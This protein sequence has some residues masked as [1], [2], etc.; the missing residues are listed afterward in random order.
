[1][2]KEL[3]RHLTEETIWMAFRDMTNCLT[4]LVI[5]VIKIIPQQDA[6][7]CNYG[8]A[9]IKIKKAQQSTKTS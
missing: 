3:K 6:T 7:P 4:P 5:K 1:M 9:K 2:A 8:M